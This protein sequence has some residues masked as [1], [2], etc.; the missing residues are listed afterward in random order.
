MSLA[1]I[2]AMKTITIARTTLIG[3]L[4]LLGGNLQSALKDYTPSGL[5]PE[6][7]NVIRAASENGLEYKKLDIYLLDAQLQK[8]ISH[9]SRRPNLNL[10]TG[11]GAYWSSFEET[12]TETDAEGN[13]LKDENG[14][15]ITRKESQ[16][17]QAGIS[18]L[19]LSTGYTL[20]N[21]GAKQAAQ[22]NTD[23]DY[24][25]FL[26]DHQNTVANIANDLRHHFLELIIQKFSLKTIELEIEVNQ[27]NI[28]QDTLRHEQGKFSNENFQRSM[29]SRKLRALSLEEQKRNLQRTVDDF[30]EK[31]GINALTLDQIPTSI[32]SIPNV[33]DQLIALVRQ[34]KSQKYQNLPEI[35]KAQIRLDKLEDNIVATKAWM[36]PSVGLSG[37]LSLDIEPTQGNQRVW[38]ASAGLGVGWNI[39]SG[40]ANSKRVL[41]ALNSKSVAMAEYMH[42]LKRKDVDMDRMIENL[43]MQYSRLEVAESEYQLALQSYEKSKEEYSRGRIS[44]LAFMSVELGRLY[45]ERAIYAS[46]RN[47][48]LT[49]SDF[50]KTMGQDPALDLLPLPE[51]K[52]LSNV[53][54]TN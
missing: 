9:A 41:K 43:L 39:Y 53:R 20:F 48:V 40:G 35:K 1:Q 51:E 49:I 27:A 46:R 8:E 29:N 12:I 10:S 19:S 50:L 25:I 37:R 23:R 45:Q 11:A 32:P 15:N 6:F 30:N 24:E 22:R 4:L 44:D 47:Y 36:K 17:I 14:N 28:D 7:K 3:I 5:Y 2:Q 52:D 18:D 33:N 16:G 26:I 34:S 31:V 54:G 13:P 42:Q 21:W 38:E